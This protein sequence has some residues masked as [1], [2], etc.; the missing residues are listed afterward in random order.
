M[1]QLDS[2]KELIAEGRVAEAV[3]RLDELLRHDGFTRK[4]EAYYLRGNAYRKTGNWQQALN[5]Y[6]YATDID[7]DS[8]ARE[9][10]RMIGDILEF[11]DKD[12]FNQ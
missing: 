2:I 10:A 6:R 8:P 11:H 4:S 9:A 1:D 3:D 12:L 5:N 7:P